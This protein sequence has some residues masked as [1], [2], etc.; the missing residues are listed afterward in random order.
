M[1]IEVLRPAKLLAKT[2]QSEDVDSA[3]AQALISQTKQNLARIQSKKF[4]KLLTVKCFLERVKSVVRKYI[5][6][7]VVLTHFEQGRETA[8]N[9]KDVWAKLISEAVPGRLKN[10]FSPPSKFSLIILNTEGQKNS[11]TDN[12]FGTEVFMSLYKYPWSKLG[13]MGLC[14]SY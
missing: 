9:S 14:H 6:L 12:K 13:S 10:D 11:D 7:D 4:E 8:K 2:F 5:F 1:A 3:E